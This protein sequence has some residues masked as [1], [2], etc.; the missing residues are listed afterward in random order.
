MVYQFHTYIYKKENFW[1]AININTVI[2]LEKHTIS[3]YNIRQRVLYIHI[4]KYIYKH[5]Q[6]YQPIA[7]R[8]L[9]S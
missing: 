8:P 5:T 3:G 7:F 4:F 1:D 9:G 6:A 2:K